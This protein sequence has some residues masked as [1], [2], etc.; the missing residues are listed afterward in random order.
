MPARGT[1]RLQIAGRGG[2]PASGVGAAVINV[3]VAGPKAAGSLT[4]FADGVARPATSN[5]NFSAGQTIPNLVVT[6]VGADGKVDLYNNSAG[7]AQ[8]VGDVLGWFQ[9]GAAAPGGLASLRPARVLDTR[10]RVGATGAIPAGGTL[11]VQVANVGGVPDSVLEGVPLDVAVTQPQKAGFLTVYPDGQPKPATSNVNFTAGQ[12]V[13]NTVQAQVGMDGK[14]DIYNASSGPVQVVADTAGWYSPSSLPL[15]GN[16]NYSRGIANPFKIAG[17]PDGALWFTNNRTGSI[18]RI[19]TDGTVSVYAN[20]NW[21][22]PRRSPPARTAPC[23]SPTATG[24][25]SGGSRPTAG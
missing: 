23:G 6:Q 18:G 15:P 14:V 12:T 11:K 16:F 22:T 7:S 24:T 13:A 20:P 10:S 5:L 1:L 17:G 21:G 3:T 4:A 19:S 2:V 8:V 9:A 25:R